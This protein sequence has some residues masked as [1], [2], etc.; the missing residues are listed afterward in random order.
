MNVEITI[1]IIN[2]QINKLKLNL[3]DNLLQYNPNKNNI[4]K[5]K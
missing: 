5:V 4:L 3:K 1:K 2:H